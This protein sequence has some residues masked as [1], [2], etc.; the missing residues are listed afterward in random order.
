MRYE[1]CAT[2]M[3]DE[4][5]RA[6][7]RSLD[8]TFERRRRGVEVGV[9]PL[10]VLLDEMGHAAGIGRRYD[11]SRVMTLAD[12]RH[13][14]RLRVGAHVGIF[15]PGEREHDPGMLASR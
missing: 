8:R 1:R 15:L 2:E 6:E 12:A 10:H 3:R 5:A 7:T 14:L 9:E 11:H 4:D 13:D